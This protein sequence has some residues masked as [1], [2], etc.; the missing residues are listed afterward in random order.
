[1]TRPT[2]SMADATTRAA[3]RRMTSCFADNMLAGAERAWAAS[4][5][6]KRSRW[7]SGLEYVIRVMPGELPVAT[8]NRSKLS[9]TGGLGEGCGLRIRKPQAP[10]VAQRLSGCLRLRA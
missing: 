4:G 3:P 10:Q 1:M 8:A 2:V 9:R 7:H 6:L 5:V